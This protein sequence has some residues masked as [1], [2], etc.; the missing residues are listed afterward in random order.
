MELRPALRTGG[1]CPTGD[2]GRRA[3]GGEV[4]RS[5]GLSSEPSDL[6]DE[7]R[8]ILGRVVVD[9]GVRYTQHSGNQLNASL[10][11]RAPVNELGGGRQKIHIVRPDPNW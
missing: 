4:V 10:Y 5:N 2:V 11:G 7:P 9:G 3:V 6:G 1:L 8:P